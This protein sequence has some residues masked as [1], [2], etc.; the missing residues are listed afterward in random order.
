MKIPTDNLFQLIQ[1][2]TASEKR[3]LKRHYASEKSITTELFDFINNMKQY[4]EDEV[5][6]NFIKSKVA[7]NLKVYKVQLTELILKSL[8]SYHNKKSIRSKI[9]IGLEETEL[10]MTKQLYS[11]AQSRVKKI[12]EI[13]LKY[14]EHEYIFAILFYE[15]MINSFFDVQLKNR[16]YPILEEFDD[17][18]DK[19]KNTYRLKKINFTLNDKN[20]NKLTEKLSKEEE[21][22]YSQILETETKKSEAGKLTF[23]EQYYLN[24]SLSLINKLVNDNPEKEYAFKK[25]NVV[26]FE[27]NPHFIENHTSYYYAALYNFLIC[28]RRTGRYDELMTGIQKIKSL[29]AEYPFLERNLSFVY[30]LEIK[31]NFQEGNYE[32]LINEFETAII[33]HIKKHNQS[34]ESLPALCFIYFTM[35]H[36]ILDHPQKV[37]FYLRRLHAM[38]KQLNPS[39]ELFFDVLEL[40]SHYETKDYE[41]IQ[42]LLSSFFRKDKKLAGN[43]T[44]YTEIL[45][46][47][48]DL[49]QTPD[50]RVFL[51]NK[52]KAKAASAEKDG[53]LNLLNEFLLDNWLTAIESNKPFSEIAKIKQLT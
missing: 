14:E 34:E 6:E 8:I 23:N 39:Y 15:I 20:N 31:H 38:S 40:I 2:M 48:A 42:N 12:K 30:Y 26:L 5:K 47:F 21:R 24:S 33:K 11:L 49:I 27:T 1:A 3:Y 37:Q 51:V 35:T 41:V 50:N 22:I 53:L 19:I 17:Y 28:C 36:M 43:D 32:A 46:F 9:R 52:L 4:D 7:K 44:F 29:T 45:D 13:C 10:L 18:T 25:K 16:E